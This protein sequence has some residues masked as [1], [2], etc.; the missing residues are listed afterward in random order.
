MNQTNHPIWFCIWF[1]E[2]KLLYRSLGRIGKVYRDKPKEPPNFALY[3]V[4][5]TKIV[6]SV[7]TLIYGVISGLAEG[8]P[9]CLLEAIVVGASDI[10]KGDLICIEHFAY[11]SKGQVRCHV[12]TVLTV[13]GALEA[14]V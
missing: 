11:R 12:L 3:L 13:P 4:R 1:G 2:P 14:I 6:V 5:R 8:H 10:K 7:L 9:Y